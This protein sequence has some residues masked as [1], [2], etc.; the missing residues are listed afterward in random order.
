MDKVKNTHIL[1]PKPRSDNLIV[2][3]SCKGKWL[4]TKLP[5]REKPRF[6]YRV[7]RHKDF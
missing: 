3:D 6:Q 4:D 7:V 5:Y 2:Y 1:P